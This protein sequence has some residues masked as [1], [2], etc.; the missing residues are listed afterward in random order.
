MK[1]LRPRE[2]AQVEDHPRPEPAPLA[3]RLQFHAKPWAGR[4]KATVSRSP[5][6]LALEKATVLKRRQTL[7]KNYQ[8]NYGLA[9]LWGTDVWPDWR[10]QGSE[11]DEGSVAVTG[12]ACQ[13]RGPSSSSPWGL[14]HTSLLHGALTREVHSAQ[15]LPT[16]PHTSLA[17]KPH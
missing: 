10:V 7:I 5:G 16:L 15:S 17:R 2:A 3:T 1:R 13:A 9:L 6:P 8:E 11:P 14:L 12:K 4:W